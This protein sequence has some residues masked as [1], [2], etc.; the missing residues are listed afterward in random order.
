MWPGLRDRVGREMV[1]PGCLSTGE[2]P[3]AGAEA[4]GMLVWRDRACDDVLSLSS[5]ESWKY[6]PENLVAA[7]SS[8]RECLGA[9]PSSSCICECVRDGGGVRCGVGPGSVGVY[10]EYGGQN[11]SES[12]AHGG[13]IPWQM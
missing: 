9:T 5:S 3:S 4:L 6:F 13:G 8:A 10:I 2:T 11:D 1:D 7:V 12:Y